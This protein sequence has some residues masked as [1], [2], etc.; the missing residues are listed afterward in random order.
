MKI[1]GVEDF[2]SSIYIIVFKCL[3]FPEFHLQ[4]L[5]EVLDVLLYSSTYISCHRYLKICISLAAF[6]CP[7]VSHCLL[8]PFPSC[9][10]SPATFAHQTP[11]QAKLKP[12]SSEQNYRQVIMWQI[13]FILLLPSQGK[14]EL[15]AYSCSFW[16]EG[17]A[18]E[19]EMS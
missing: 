13:S 16:E 11:N 10:P 18:R 2:F 9:D 19:V 8:W 12:V 14:Q 7:S 15:A 3:D 1:R 17:G 5:L 4:F 6:T